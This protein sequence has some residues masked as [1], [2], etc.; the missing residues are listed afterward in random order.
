MAYHRR[1]FRTLGALPEL[2][3]REVVGGHVPEK[4]RRPAEG[5]SGRGK[6][7]ISSEQSMAA[8]CSTSERAKVY[9]SGAS[10]MS[11]VPLGG[12]A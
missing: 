1:R 8:G 6:Q 9:S 5:G 7:L 10:S 4:D 11:L 2:N 3:S 12:T